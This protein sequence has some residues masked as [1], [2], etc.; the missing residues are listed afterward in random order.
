M[1]MSFSTFTEPCFE[2]YTQNLCNQNHQNIYNCK[3][4]LFSEMSKEILHQ[5]LKPKKETLSMALK[6]HKYQLLFVQTENAVADR[7]PKTNYAHF[8]IFWRHDDTVS[9]DSQIFKPT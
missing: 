8:E 9:L 1:F 6:L 3:I 2:T 5:D 4:M 7:L